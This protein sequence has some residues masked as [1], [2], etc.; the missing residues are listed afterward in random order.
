MKT[1][2]PKKLKKGDV[3]AIVSPSGS[4]PA[5]LKLQFDRGADLLRTLGL[6]SG[7]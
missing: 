2:K 1:I 6:R 5:E 3:V 7:S 4:V